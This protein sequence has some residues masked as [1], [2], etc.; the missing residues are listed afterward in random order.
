[1]KR[2]IFYIAVTIEENGKFWSYVIK[3]GANDNLLSTLKIKNITNASLYN[4]KKEAV[5]VVSLWNTEYIMNGASLFFNERE[6]TPF[7]LKT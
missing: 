2:K 5:A 3:H 7:W 4:T 1:M 6:A